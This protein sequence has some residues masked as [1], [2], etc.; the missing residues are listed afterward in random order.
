MGRCT[1]CVMQSGPESCSIRKSNSN[2]KNFIRERGNE[3]GENLLIL[4]LPGVKIWVGS[5]GI[6]GGGGRNGSRWWRSCA[7]NKANEVIG[8]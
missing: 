1:I 2:G 5:G 3:P 8:A 6:R 7:I 4:P